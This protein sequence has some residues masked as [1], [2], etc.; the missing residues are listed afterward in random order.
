ML[1]DDG[2]N[3]TA[4]ERIPRFGRRAAVNGDRTASG[5]VHA[6]PLSARSQPAVWAKGDEKDENEQIPAQ[7][8]LR[9][10]RGMRRR[11]AAR[12]SSDGDFMTA[13]R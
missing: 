4:R 13:K 5:A 10:W 7:C 6:A 8:G 2:E 9:Y 11:A 12:G 3:G 1:D